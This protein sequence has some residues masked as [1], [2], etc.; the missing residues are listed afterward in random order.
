MQLQAEENSQVKVFLTHSNLKSMFTEI[1]LDKHLIISQLK[2]KLQ[3]HVGT[4]AA[5]M[6]I[7]LLDQDAQLVSQDLQDDKLLGFY[8]PQNGYII[9]VI[10]LDPSSVTQD[11]DNLD[12]VQKYTMSDEDYD[13][14]EDT[15]RKFKKNVLGID[16]V[17]ENKIS[18]KETDIQQQIENI[19]IGQR[20][21]IQ[22]GGRRGEVKFVGFIEDLQQKYWVGVQLDE[23][24]GKNDGKIGGKQY[25]SCPQ[26]YGVFVQPSNVEVGD[27]PAIDVLDMLGSDDEI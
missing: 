15:F 25:F 26:R 8:S 27:F 24:T 19:K 16:D 1:R 13:K 23:P 4:S 9:H 6:K 10:D 21:E 17:D 20:C 18:N 22:P 7:N 12:S 11:L 14:R 5:S 2:F 3:S